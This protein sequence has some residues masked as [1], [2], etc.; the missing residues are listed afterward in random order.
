[1]RKSAS[2]HCAESRRTSRIDDDSRKA[3]IPSADLLVL[4]PGPSSANASRPAVPKAGVNM[5]MTVVRNVQIAQ[6]PRGPRRPTHPIV[7]VANKVARGPGRVALHRTRQA[8]TERLRREL[9]RPPARRPPDQV[10]GG[11]LVRLACA[12]PRGPDPLEGR[13]QYRAATQRHRQPAARRLRQARRTR[14]ATG[15]GA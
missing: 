10:R 1:M 9:Q 8:A 12:R 2:E 13:L 15:W 11:D 4:R 6:T 5:P 7:A 14:D 3:D